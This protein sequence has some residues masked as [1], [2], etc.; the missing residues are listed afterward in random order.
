MD[1]EDSAKTKSTPPQ[2]A[3]TGVKRNGPGHGFL[4]AAAWPPGIQAMVALSF[5][6]S[7]ACLAP[8][9][10]AEEYSADGFDFNDGT[11]QGWTMH[12]VSV[13]PVVVRVASN[14]SV[15]WSDTTD[16]PG[17]PESSPTG[18]DRGALQLYTPGGHGIEG[19]N[20]VDDYWVIELLSPDLSSSQT[21]QQAAGFTVQIADWTADPNVVIYANEHVLFS[22]PNSEGLRSFS[23]GNA[24]ALS[25]GQWQERAYNWHEGT[26]PFPPNATIQRIELSIWG[27]MTTGPELAGSV[28]IDEVQPIRPPATYYVDANGGGPGEDGSSDF[29][30]D[31]IQ[32][33]VD[34]ALVGDTVLINDGIYT[35]EGNWDI[36]LQGESIVVQS[37]NGPA[38]CVIRCQT[39]QYQNVPAFRFHSGETDKTVLKGLT[40]AGATGASA[41]ACVES[42]PTLLNC[43]LR[44]N[45]TANGGGLYCEAGSPTIRNCVFLDNQAD[46]GAAVY[47]KRS[48]LAIAHCTAVGNEAAIM[49]GAIHLVESA[50]TVTNC[51][52]WD[53]TGVQG[54]QLSLVSSSTATAS[55]CILGNGGTKDCYCDASSVLDRTAGNLSE[56]PLLADDGYHLQPDSPCIEAG[57]PGGAYWKRVDIDDTSRLFNARVDIGAD[58]YS[59]KIPNVTQGTHA[60]TIQEAIDLASDGDIIEVPSGIYTGKANHLIDFWGKAITLRSTDGPAR[61][62]IDC[63]GRWEDDDTRLGFMFVHGEGPDSVLDGLTVRN[64]Y[65]RK[66][67]AVVITGSSPTIRNCRFVYNRSKSGGAAILNWEGNPTITNCLFLNNACDDAGA[68]LNYHGNAT[69]NNCTFIYNQSYGEE[70]G[71]ALQCSSGHTEI[72]NCVFWNNIVLYRECNQIAMQNRSN[73][74]TTVRITHS[75]IMGGREGIYIDSLCSLDWGAGNIDVDPLLTPDG[76][77][78][79]G[80]PCID[81]G[82]LLGAP[83]SDGEAESRPSGEGLDM[84]SDEYVDSDLDQLPDYWEEYFFGSPTDALANEDVDGDTFSN[85]EECTVFGSNPIAPPHFVDGDNGS[86]DYDGLAAQYE[87]GSRGPKRTIQAGI[88]AAGEGDTMLVAAGT[89]SGIGNVNLQ[90]WGK[91][92][93][94]HA[95]EG[96]AVTTIDCEEAARGFFFWYFE[97]PDT[98]VSGFTVAHGKTDSVGGAVVCVA[99]P[100]IRN[101]VLTDSEAAN[102]GGFY[103]E[104]GAPILENCRMEGNRPNGVIAAWCCIHLTGTTKLAGNNYWLTEKIVLTGSGTLELEPGASAYLRD[105]RVRCNLRGPG[106]LTV[107]FGYDLTIEG[108]AVIDLGSTAGNGQILCHGMLRARDQA[109]IRNT[110]INITR[111][112]FEGDVDV[113]NNVIN[114]EVGA[115]YGQFFIEDTVTVS[116]NEIH[117]DGD[118]YMDLDPSVFAGVIANN[119]IYVTITEGQHSTRGGLLELRGYDTVCS[120]GSTC[121]PGAFELPSVPGFDTRTWTIEC[122]ELEPGAQVSLTNRFDFGN[123]GFN[124]VM[125]AKQ[126]VLGEGSVLNTA[127]NRLYYGQMADYGGRIVNLPLLGFSLNMI[128]FDDENEFASRVVHNNFIHPQTP[129]YD[130]THVAR[131]LEAPDPA[132][133]MRMRNLKDQDPASLTYGEVIHARAKGLFAK[134]SENQILI[135]FEYLF[136]TDDPNTELAVYLSDV[137]ELQAPRDP[138]HYLE[139]G[140]LRP[141]ARG[142]PG[143]VNSGRFG[144]FHRYVSKGH[145]NFI[146]GTRVELELVALDGG[147]VLIND[148]DPQIHCPEKICLD[149]V[150]NQAPLDPLDLIAVL[151]ACGGEAKLGADGSGNECFDSVLSCNGFLDTDDVVSFEYAARA[152][153]EG[154]QDS[155][156]P[157]QNAGDRGLPLTTTCTSDGGEDGSTALNRVSYLSY[158]RPLWHEQAALLLLGKPRWD[159]GPAIPSATDLLAIESE[160]LYSVDRQGR[161]VQTTILAHEYANAALAC[162]HNGAVYQI[163]VDRGVLKLNDNGTSSSLITPGQVP[164][165]KEP[166]YKRGAEVYVGLQIDGSQLYGRPIWDV[167]FDADSVYVVPVVVVPDSSACPPY[168]SAAKLTLTNGGSPG[169]RV[170][171]LYDD[172]DAPDWTP[173]NPHLGGLREIDVDDE[174]NVYIINA[175]NRNESDMLWKYGADGTV[176][177]LCLNTPTGTANIPDPIGLCVSSSTNTVYLASGQIDREC[178]QTTTIYGFSTDDLTLK[179]RITVENMEV[180]TDI[181]E[182][183]T[184]GTLWAVGFIYPTRSEFVEIP[185][186]ENVKE[187]FYQPRLA[188]ISPDGTAELIDIRG[189]HDLAMPLSI[190]FR[191]DGGPAIAARP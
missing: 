135:F 48:T 108:N 122:L 11:M 2:V 105:N 81:A 173:G 164:C 16:Y 145:L 168:L 95:L 35:G 112:S 70:A 129:A 188:K 186:W 169:Y 22:D 87:T 146:R 184:T 151:A 40:I 26:D 82:T 163:A 125:Y 63:H 170:E 37:L 67:G 85:L 52:L 123:G 72:N 150:E 154:F 73:E 62:I 76:H 77:L 66:G 106:R 189:D 102:G 17:D 83:G 32:E 159:L 126:L 116:D 20:S 5:L 157:L 107:P 167:A 6:C 136:E 3:P 178:S 171:E 39:D 132:G 94:L 133:M 147:S 124:E 148:W 142:R 118:R 58:E 96:P 7:A 127:Y 51:V 4:L 134:S 69:I 61:C 120:E 89:Y 183:P 138:D 1:S 49:G 144:T 137:P 139:V 28:Y 13:P 9:W 177:R 128:R 162:D 47:A 156:C 98:V 165:E 191:S 174:G 91:P 90:T 57:Q 111:A 29:P 109:Q 23:P 36:D 46:Y 54:S 10:A 12:R 74:P 19:P 14:F 166:R 92:M 50:A 182:D 140:R 75:D 187:S 18:D 25:H 143:S 33:A 43:I 176:Q 65:T 161:H 141:P 30:F 8:A 155:L 131:V 21:W 34:L 38:N 97:I 44:D 68:M 180:V 121:E 103:A 80:S 185:A 55:Y 152:Y 56:D 71:G 99:S 24:T 158:P 79:A 160:H 110:T 113:S 179:R 31:T 45:R 59:P 149:F 190:L 53:N 175:Y 86:D 101:C 78:R 93:V 115:P 42:S 130:R 15:G 153:Y 84:G 88:D 64:G 41:I 100:R 181:T 104:Y 172:P 119:R 114:A 60:N 27:S 117:A